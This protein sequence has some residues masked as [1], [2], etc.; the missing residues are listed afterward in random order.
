MYKYKYV[1]LRADGGH[2]DGLGHIKRCISLYKTIKKDFNH[3]IPI[4]IVN[5]NNFISIKILKINNCKYLTV[6]GRVNT[7]NEV[8]DL[9]KILT[10]Y[11]SKVLIIDS[12][13]INKKYISY[14]KNFSKIVVF[15]DEKKYNFKPDLLINNNIWAKKFHKNSSVKLLGLKYNTVPSK[16]FKK[17]T[18][19]VRSKKILISMG[20][21]DPNNMT[22]E[23]ISIFSKLVLNLKFVIILG[24]SHP[25]KKSVINFCKKNF[26]NSKIFVSPEDISICLKR[27]R[28]IISA[29]GLSAYEFA[30]ARIPQLIV[31]L[32]KHQFKIANMIKAKNCGE[33]LYRFGQFNKKKLSNQFINFYNNSSK[34]LKINKSAKRLIKSSGCKRIINYILN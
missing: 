31:V 21:E 27:L 20:G 4:F 24:H 22:L 32:D 3:C 7:K 30:S 19:D 34:L 29:G 5:K 23:L 25:N 1:F 11:K 18:F 8:L 14:L 16:F 10:F 15:E 28:L 26:I 33:V 6:N 9:T 2:V 12:K 17:N 13:R